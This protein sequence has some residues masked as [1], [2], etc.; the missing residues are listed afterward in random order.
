MKLPIKMLVIVI[1][2][3]LMSAWLY[4]SGNLPYGA[5]P[6]RWLVEAVNSEFPEAALITSNLAH[7]TWGKFRA[8]GLSVPLTYTER[9]KRIREI[10]LEVAALCNQIITDEHGGVR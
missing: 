3:V 1:V 9:I 5:P 7:V 10:R 6:A 8:M 4:A 2:S